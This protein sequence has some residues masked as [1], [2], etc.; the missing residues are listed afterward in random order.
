MTDHHYTLT[1][2]TIVHRGQTLHRIQ[3]LADLPQHGVKVGDVGGWVQSYA[4]LKGAAWVSGEAK[5]YGLATVRDNAYVSGEAEVF[6]QAEV[7]QQ[8]HVHHRAWVTGSA[9][10]LGQARVYDD[11]T[12]KDSAIIA[13]EAQVY[14]EAVVSGRAMLID[15]ARVGGNVRPSDSM[16]LGSQT[17]LEGNLDLLTARIYIN[18]PLDVILTRQDNQAGHLVIIDSWAG[19]IEELEEMAAQDK[20]VRAYGQQARAEI[21]SLAGL[22]AARVQRW[23]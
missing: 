10:V 11:A 12:I 7:S 4:N 19:T 13:D 8:A 2:Q 23:K 18:R 14:G 22:L 5:V 16:T 20:W 15:Q 9:R 3:A 6:G 17:V 21:Q 1:D